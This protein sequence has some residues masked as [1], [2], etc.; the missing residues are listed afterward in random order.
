MQL[1]PREDIQLIPAL[2][3]VTEHVRKSCV[4]VGHQEDLTASWPVSWPQA[5]QGSLPLSP[6]SLKYIFYLLYAC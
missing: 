4:T 3:Q 2:I 1:L 6:L 5:I